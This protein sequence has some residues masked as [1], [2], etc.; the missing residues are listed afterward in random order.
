MLTFSFILMHVWISILVTIIS[1]V[2]PC[3]R[4]LMLNFQ[5][6]CY[7]TVISTD[8]ITSELTSICTTDATVTLFKCTILSREKVFKGLL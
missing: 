5:S 3:A 6:Q 1:S 4:E 2:T 8:N 7:P